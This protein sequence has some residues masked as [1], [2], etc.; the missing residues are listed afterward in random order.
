MTRRRAL[1]A[2]APR[3]AVGLLT[4]CGPPAAADPGLAAA[5]G[6]M[7]TRMFDHLRAGR[8]DAAAFYVE[9]ILET[10]EGARDPEL[11]LVA[12][13]LAA[14]RCDIGEARRHCAAGADA[15]GAA[16]PDL[17]DRLRRLEA[18]L[19]GLYGAV[20][21]RVGRAEHATQVNWAPGVVPLEADDTTDGATVCLERAR[22]QLAELTSRVDAGCC[23]EPTAARL[24]LPVGRYRL[25]EASLDVAPM[26]P[27]ARGEVAD[28]PTL[29]IAG[30]DHTRWYWVGG[31]LGVAAITTGIILAVPGDPAETRTLRGRLDP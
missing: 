22:A 30:P 26:A 15:A 3:L 16:R 27:S 19:G 18:D 9:R 31:V 23:A 25:G 21:V 29:W 7:R 13:R 10:A 5:P 1:S 12:A 17:A 14:G 2:L 6:E 28:G 11:R 24:I 20:D 4:V 8:F